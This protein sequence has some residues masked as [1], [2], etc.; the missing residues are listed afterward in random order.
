MNPKH[1]TVGPMDQGGRF[2]GR[3]R[4]GGGAGHEN[5]QRLGPQ[6]PPKSWATPVAGWCMPWKPPWKWMM[7]GSSP[8]L[9][10]LH[11]WNSTDQLWSVDKT[12]SSISCKEYHV[13]HFMRTVY[14]WICFQP[15]NISGI[16][17]SINVHQCP[18]SINSLQNAWWN[19]SSLPKMVFPE[20]Q[21][22]FRMGKRDCES[23]WYWTSMDFTGSFDLDHPCLRHSK[24]PGRF[25]ASGPRDQPSWATTPMAFLGAI[26][27]ATSQQ[28]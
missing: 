5:P 7:T 6:W 23:G 15:S 3:R 22:L 27:V 21:K 24:K 1:W 25:R 13:W 16:E 18:S 28:G 9:G 20:A 10:N 19:W 26:S 17:F 11:L 8:I 2:H 4:L 12:F 14:A